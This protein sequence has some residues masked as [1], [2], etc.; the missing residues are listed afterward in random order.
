MRKS[1]FAMLLAVCGYTVQAQQP[2]TPELL[3]SLSR[4]GAETLTPDGAKVIYGVT[5]YD[6]ATGTSERDLFSVDFTGKSPMQI[7]KTK[8]GESGVFTLPNGKMGYLYKG[9]VWQAEWD[10][11]NPIQFTD[12][13]GGISNIRFSPDGKHIL[14]SKDVQLQKI[15]SS[16]MYKD[17]PN[18]SVKVYNDLNYRHWDTWEDG[19]YSH[20]FI[21]TMESGKIINEKDIM[22]GQLYDC[23]QMPFG[24]IE[25]MVWHPDS[26][27]IIYVTKQKTG[28]AYTTSTNTDIFVYDIETGKTKNITEGMQGYDMSPNISPDGSKVAWLSMERD[29]Y[30]ADKNRIFILDR[31]SDLKIDVTASYDE[32]VES[33]RWSNDG[34]YIYFTSAINGTLQLFELDV[35]NSMMKVD[36]GGKKRNPIRQITSGDFDITGVVGESNGLLIVTRT[37]MNHAAEIFKVDIAKGDITAITTTNQAKYDQIGMCKTERK[38]VKTTDGKDMLVWFIYP[39]NFD[40]NKKYPTLLYCQGGPQSA[41]TQFY[42]F[43]WNFQLMASQG[44]IVV[45]PNRR[46]MPGHGTEW[47]EQISGDWGGQAINDYYSAIDYAKTLPYVDANRC[48]AVGASYGGYSVYMMA[49]THNG[50]FKTFIAHDGLFNLKSFYGTT[51]EMWFA[52]WDMGGPY[53]T[54]GEQDKSYSTFNPMNYVD[55]WNTPILIYQGGKD[56]RTTEDQAFQAFQAAQLRGIKSRFVYLP[57]ENHW[58]LKCQNAL[59]WQ[60][61]FYKWLGETL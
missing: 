21:A 13:D 30:E 47:N 32:S 23:P 44:Y 59:A 16:D 48:G 6:I 58:V 50:R 34:K 43:R 56:Y 55:K 46:G 28:T 39:P 49:G 3:W 27:H 26:K 17:L 40:P 25:D 24:G 14:F 41:L 42:S 61:E 53:W 29:G 12:Y 33:I 54:S 60:R 45:A 9:Q 51:D 22:A 35:T 1:F 7:T 37:D 52:N 57:D 10:G 4:V 19:A 15:A 18:A 36:E 5:N 2:L 20:L 8:G 38:M 31:K 11:S